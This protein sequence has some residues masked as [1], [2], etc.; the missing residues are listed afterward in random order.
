M[1]FKNGIKRA[2][3]YIV[4]GI[5]VYDTRVVINEI[6]GN[7][8]LKNKT[9]MITGGGRG[10]GFYIARKCAGQG[11]SILIT[12]RNEQTLQDA[13]K[14][15]EGNVQY[16]IYDVQDVEKSEE[17]IRLATE[18]LGGKIDCLVNNAGI[19]LHEGSYD[20]VTIESFEKQVNTNLK[21][22]YFLAQAYLKSICPNHEGN[23]L[24]V[25]SERGK[26][27]DDIPYGLTKAAI[28][29]LTRG[30]SRRVYKSGVRVNAIAPGVT[31]SDMTGVDRNE[32]LYCEWMCSERYFLPEEVAEVAC[33][34]L[35]DAS[36]CISGEVIACD[37]GQYLNP[38]FNN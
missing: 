21:G 11:A 33:F 8:I 28:N 2:L 27:C 3:K 20:N 6:N 37:A 1:R 12:G 18:K 32:N 35:S 25:S 14:K 7:N 31:A 36:K 34:L 17:I 19:S 23:I 10:L 15:I 13:V 30:L 22:S 9:I 4:K 26:Q 16:M 24:F 29:S 5:P 38:W